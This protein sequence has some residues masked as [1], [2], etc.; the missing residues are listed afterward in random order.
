MKIILQQVA[1]S[2]MMSILDSFSGY[3]QIRVKRVDKYKTTFITPW[4]TFAY[5]RMPFGL[6]NVGST[7]KIAMQ[8]A[9]DDLIRKIIQIYLDDLTVYSKNRSDCVGHLKR[10][11]MRCRKFDISLNPSKSIFG[12]TKI[13]GH[14]VSDLGIS[15]DP[16]RIASILNLP[17]PTSKKEVQTFMAVIN[18]DCRFVPN[19]AVMVKTIHNLLKQDHS[20]SW[21]NDVENSFVGIKKA[22]NSAPVLAK[23]DFDKEFTIYTNATKEAIS[24]ILMQCDDQENEKP[25]AYMSQILSDD[26]FKYSFIEKHAFALVKAVEIFCHFIL[27]KQMLVKVPLP[28][29]KFFLS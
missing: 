22:I 4:G 26:E 8:I 13:L 17:P 24:S 7:F 19:F 10:V 9:F 1:G 23:P 15:I 21:T 14:I 20:F 2:Q 6:S 16:E 3:N 5:E 18:F 25:V 27:G 28:D 29:V 12:I 11:L